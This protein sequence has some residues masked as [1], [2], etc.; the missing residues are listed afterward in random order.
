M[1]RQKCLDTR[2]RK[3]SDSF[4]VFSPAV[5]KWLA[6]N[7]VPSGDGLFLYLRDISG[8]KKKDEVAAGLWR[9]A[10]SLADNSPDLILRFDKSLS[11]AFANRAVERLIDVPR[12]Q[13][14]GKNYK[15]MGLPGETAERLDAS[16]LRVVKT[17]TSQ[18]V[19]FDL[20]TKK[21]RKVFSW[22]AVPETDEAEKLR[23]VLIVARDVTH[24][25]EEERV[26]QRLAAAIEETGEGVVLTE[27]DGT[28]AYVN[29]AFCRIVECEKTEAVGTKIG[30]FARDGVDAGLVAA[31]KIALSRGKPWSGRLDLPKEIAGLSVDVHVSPIKNASGVI[32]GFV[33]IVRDVTQ[34]AALE[35]QLRESQ[36]LESLGTLSGGIAHDFNNMLAVIIG[37]AE[38]ALEDSEKDSPSR[39]YLNQTIGAAMRS[40]DLVKQILSFSRKS[41]HRAKSFDLASLVRDTANLLRSSL[42]TT[43][44]MR[45]EIDTVE[46]TVSADPTQIQQV[47]MNIATNASQAMG[48]EGVMTMG[49]REVCFDPED[50]LPDPGL[51]PGEYLVLSISD[52]GT[53]MDE[54]VRRR[55]F[56]PFF[57]TK[58][59]GKGTGLGLS[60]VYGIVKAHEGAVIVESAKGE[61]STFRV[62]LPKGNSQGP[63]A[64]AEEALVP[65]G[66]GR[67]LFIDDEESIASMARIALSKLGY[68]V[69]A[70]TDPRAALRI[71]LKDPDRFNLVVTDQTMPHMSGLTLAGRLLAARPDIPII[72]ST[73]YSAV[74]DQKT[75][76]DAGITAFVMKPLTREQLARAVKDALDGAAGRQPQQEG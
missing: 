38:L 50:P 43:I 27:T 24:E 7:C 61:G 25:R 71:F 57:T 47:I 23:S 51:R 29:D 17:G 60:V 70:E 48:Q 12:K 36:K 28:I 73:G 26:R 68:D 33:G 13:L 19:E 41:V 31:I 72:L 18:S 9:E 2:A 5:K 59:V 8:E 16:L 37:N 6:V 56:E 11:C 39:H 76:K 4:E 40:R 34:E 74:V 10:R 35:S 21:G 69:R 20:N 55:I 44:E 3:S 52:T 1:F 62:F 67:V 46:D 53:G 63:E 32:T 54:A 64:P 58:E 30:R 22:R 45:L 15:T 42:P 14:I 65:R 66:K 75:A 49:L